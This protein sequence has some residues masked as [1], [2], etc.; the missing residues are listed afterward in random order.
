V[1]LAIDWTNEDDQ[2]LLGVSLIVGRR[3]ANLL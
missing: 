1:R 2:H 3:A